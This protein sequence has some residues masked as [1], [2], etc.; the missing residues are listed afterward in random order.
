[1]RRLSVVSTLTLC[2][3]LTAAPANAD[4]EDLVPWCSADQTPTN[5]NCRPTEG[6]VF[7]DDGPG[8]NPELPT[9]VDPGVAPIV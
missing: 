1:M 6:Q 9:G 3:V 8:A 2:A 7:E 5:S 4:P